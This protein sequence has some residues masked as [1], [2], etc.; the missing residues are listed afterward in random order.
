MSHIHIIRKKLKL[1]NFFGDRCNNPLCQKINNLE[2]AHIKP[3]KLYGEGRGSNKRIYDIQNNITSYILL[4][5]KCHHDFDNKKKGKI[6]I[7][8]IIHFNDGSTLKY[9]NIEIKYSETGI[10]TNGEEGKLFI[11]Y[12]SVKFISEEN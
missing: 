8:G 6:M 10:F 7:K 3:T 5:K 11:P 4:C 9:K 1:I 2:F 12:C